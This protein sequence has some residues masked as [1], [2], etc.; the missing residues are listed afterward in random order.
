MPLNSKKIRDFRKGLSF[1][2]QMQVTQVTSLIIA[3]HILMEMHHLGEIYGP[4]NQGLER[5]QALI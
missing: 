2:S 1:L 3:L 4:S 5:K